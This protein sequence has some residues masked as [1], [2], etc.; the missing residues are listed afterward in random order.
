MHGKNLLFLEGAD[1][2]AVFFHLLSYYE[3]PIAEKDR[4]EEGK[5]SLHN[6]KGINRLLETL[7][8]LLKAQ[9]TDIEWEVIGVVIDADTNLTN[10]WQSMRDLLMH[11]GYT[12][13]PLMPDA[14]GTIVY[15]QDR[16]TIGIWIMPDNVLP[17]MIEHFVQ[18]L[19]PDGDPLWEK[20]EQCVS[21]IPE[22]Q[23]PFI[24]AHFAKAHVHTW[25][26]W[27]E[28]PGNPMGLAITK[29]YLNAE[30]P[31]AQN[32]ISWIRQLFEIEAEN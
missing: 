20:A 17:G 8:V 7:Q 10:R 25:L 12:D 32:L 5:I 3:I 29:R 30:A 28:T 13:I 11:S 15:E 31:H 22:H 14:A 18:F 6:G 9:D 1:D 19:V 23:R 26:A 24:P 2:V 27:Q 4:S 16:P 21:N